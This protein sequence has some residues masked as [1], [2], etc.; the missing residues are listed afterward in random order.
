MILL[1]ATC[2]AMLLAARVHPLV[3]AAVAMS[4]AVPLLALGAVAGAVAWS[5]WRRNQ[6]SKTS[7]P[8][9]AAVLEGLAAAVGSGATVRQAVMEV[10]PERIGDE[11][12][13]R[14]A[15]GRPMAEIAEAIARRF[16]VTGAEL[17]VV[18]DQSERAGA[19]TAVALHELS[20]LAAAAEQRRRDVRV[21][22]A[23]SRFS[24][25]VVGVVPL[26]AALAVVALRGIPEP[27]GP[28][29]VGSMV[30]G[31]MLMIIGSAVVFIASGRAA[32]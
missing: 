24:A 23:Q 22:A 15:A 29:V 8:P 13:R 7:G 28:L 16:S 5:V 14:C 1:A 31:S 9:E 12:L 20:E 27:G 32:S 18:L 17:G 19:K 10:S 26:V 11:V 6:T 30:L 25:L 21:A 3:V 4:L 2:A